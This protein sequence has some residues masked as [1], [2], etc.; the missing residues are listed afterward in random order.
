MVNRTAAV[1]GQS[2]RWEKKYRDTPVKQTARKTRDNSIAR[3]GAVS[4]KY[5]MHKPA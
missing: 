1:N 3:A 4:T 2:D 5:C